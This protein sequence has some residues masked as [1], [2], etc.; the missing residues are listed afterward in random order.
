MIIPDLFNEIDSHLVEYWREKI[1]KEDRF[2]YIEKENK[3]KAK[4]NEKLDDETKELVRLYGTIIVDKMEHINYEI[5]SR[6]F[7]FSIKSGMDMQK[8]FDKTE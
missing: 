6:L 5:C 1:E 7:I 3:V 2:G 4:L 8:A